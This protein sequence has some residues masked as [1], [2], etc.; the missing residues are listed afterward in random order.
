MKPIRLTLRAFGSYGAE[1]SVDFTRPDQNLFL[2]TGDTGAGKTTLF[3]AIVFALYGEA[4]S[5]SNRKDGQELQSQFADY[6]TSPFVELVFSER[7]QVYTVR[8]SPA[9][10]RTKKRGAG[11]TGQSEAVALT[12]PDGSDYPHRDVDRKL[13]E[14]VGLTK[15]QFMQVAM[16]AQGEF[17]E[18]LRAKSDDKKVI[19]RKLFGTE[20]YQR[21]VAELSERVRARRAEIGQIRT[22]CQTE[23]AHIAVPED[24][25]EAAGMAALR[26][27]I[28]HSER[29]NVADMERLMAGLDALCGWLE[30]RRDAAKSACDAQSG[31][32]D[33]HRDRLTAAEALSRSFDQLRRAE[34]TLADCEREAPAIADAGKLIQ[35]IDAAY[36]ILGVHRACADADAAVKDAEAKL[37]ARREELPR[38]IEAREAASKAEAEARETRDAALRACTV[39]AERVGKALEILEKIDSARGQAQKA[40]AERKAAEANLT[41]ATRAR[42]AFE[43]RILE[44][45]RQ[46]EQLSGAGAALERWK[47]RR[48]EVDALAGNCAE[49]EAAEKSV[50]SQ[51][52]ASEKARKE[53]GRAREAH[54]IAS[55]EYQSKQVAFLDAQAGFIAQR[56]TPGQPCPVCGSLEHPNICQLSETHTGLTREII[57]DLAAREKRLNEALLRKSEAAQAALEVLKERTAQ[58]T[59]MEEKLCARMGIEPRR[60]A[61]LPARLKA[62]QS[63]V[64]AEGARVQADARAFEQAQSALKG[65]EARRKALAEAVELATKRL[66]AA[67]EALA[68]L[69]ARLSGL[70]AQRDFPTAAE[71]KAALADAEAAKNAAAAAHERARAAFADAGARVESCQA[72]IGRYTEELP[73]LHDT[74]RA[75]REAY[76]AALSEH[77][78]G[79]AEWQDVAA[80]HRRAETARLQSRIS[81]HATRK[82]A[83]QGAMEAAK[84]A[85]GDRE[86]PDLDALRAA[87]SQADAALTAI[88]AEYDAV[89]ECH[90]VN[91][92]TLEA[93]RPRLE[94]RAGVMR[95]YSRVESLYRRLSGNETGARMDIETYVQ[96][97]YLDRILRAAN[98]RFREMSAGQFELRM[99]PDD[100]AGV[101]KNRGLDLMVY[102]NVTGKSREVRTLSG[103]ESFMAALSLALG[104]AD[105]IQQSASAIHLDV[106]FIDEGFGSLDDHARGQAVRVLR[107]MAGGEKLI[108]IISHVT[109]LKSEIDDQLLVTKDERGSHTQWQIS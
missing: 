84:K 46:T 22:A 39:T 108:G 87:V 44:W 77:D 32:R 45:Q 64:S 29:M 21:I 100:M 2:I 8:R 103:G 43:A 91:R 83:A 73:G 104:M 36:A 59:S 62:L 17:M 56:L 89:R 86:P 78:M 80:K 60:A 23:V 18:L 15:D 109:E 55:A 20:L 14:I 71:A 95:A 107:Q 28:L 5:T 85:I 52:A 9:H 25:P 3:D 74:R 82:A 92:A 51:R 24:Y 63:E 35:S 49:L 61:D 105:Q 98:L 53:Y 93:L 70:E 47:A 72:L 81:A 67:R 88:Q 54:Q 79:E 75:R 4:S 97:Y 90:R 7:G 106:M 50:T 27:R 11:I 96:R 48:A 57:D 40:E 34:E 94:E 10:L 99:V 41:D 66:A 31:Q 69:S 68:G 12:L 30:A 102:S 33:A 1:Q 101:G 19:F 65:A 58:Y 6:D 42:D 76:D 38:L 37:A 13:E 26:Q 16:I